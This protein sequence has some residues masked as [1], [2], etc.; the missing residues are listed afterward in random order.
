ML[1][2]H[3]S[4][5][6]TLIVSSACKCMGEGFCTS[7]LFIHLGKMYGTRTGKEVL[8]GG[9]PRFGIVHD[10]HK[11]NYDGYY[12]IQQRSRDF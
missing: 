6:P 12:I 10:V 8:L 2:A 1:D 7:V 4:L 5:P 9:V 11:L 3:A